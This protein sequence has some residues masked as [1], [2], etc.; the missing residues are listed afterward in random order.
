MAPGRKNVRC[1]WALRSVARSCSLGVGDGQSATLREMARADI[2]PQ[3]GA[4]GILQ[5]IRQLGG[6]LVES[7]S[8][9]ACRIWLWRSGRHESGSRDQEPPGP[10][11]GELP[12]GQLVSRTSGCSRHPGQRLRRRPPWPRRIS[13][14]GRGGAACSSSRS[15]PASAADSCTTASCWAPAGQPPA[16]SDTC[17]P[18]CTPWSPIRPSSHWP[19]A[20]ASRQPPK[21]DWPAK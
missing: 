12:P 18:A 16:K 15:A 11:L 3:R 14:Q 2:D 1:I 20:G 4:A 10:G 8:R 9:H 5:Q 13:G 19:A 6:A 21:P 7:H 17:G